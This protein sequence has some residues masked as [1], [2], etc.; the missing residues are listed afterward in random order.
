MSSRSHLLGPTAALA[1]L[2]ACVSGRSE[3]VP[4]GPQPAAAEAAPVAAEPTAAGPAAAEADESESTAAEPTAA[5]PTATEPTATEPRGAEPTQVAAAP[6]ELEPAAPTVPVEMVALEPAVV[7][8]VLT[9]D[10]LSMRYSDG[11]AGRPVVLI[12][13]WCGNQ[14]QWDAQV[15]DLRRTHRVLCV[16]LVGHG[17][18]AGQAREDWTVAAFGDDVARLLEQEALEG[19]VLVGHSMG[20]PVA[21]EAAVRAPERVAAVVGVESMHRLGATPDPGQRAAYVA[22]F[23][24]DFPAAMGE[25]VRAAVHPDAPAEVRDRIVAESAACDPGMAVALMEHFGS[26]D[27]R[28]A[29]RVVDCPVRC[30]NSETTPTDVAGNRALLTSFDVEQVSGTG[31]WPQ[32]EVPGAFAE[33]LGAT[34]A[35]LAPARGPEVPAVVTSFAPVVRCEDLTAVREFYVRHLRFEVVDCAPDEDPDARGSVTLV[36]DGATLV[37]QSL[38]SLRGDLPEVTLRPGPAVLRMGVTNLG[39]E[40]RS[41]GDALRVVVPERRL[42]DGSRQVVV[43]DPAGTLVVLRQG[44][45]LP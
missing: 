34:L 10:G 35:A 29:T 41:L 31:H 33:A 43:E 3:V 15:E 17:A 44:P 14:G 13:G 22:R 4:T 18:S 8:G 2:C 27:P 5:E 38:A 28:P 19:A 21:L 23:R 42:A 1:L 20:G 32:V 11:G 7:R 30:I 36:R 6:P 12:H 37:L 25:F 9:A 39:D 24:A 45:D 26:Y 16:D 40:L